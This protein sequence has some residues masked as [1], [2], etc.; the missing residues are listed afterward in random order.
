MT[1]RRIVLTVAALATAIAT[2]PARGQD[3][4]LAAISNVEVRASI[5]AVIVE[6]ERRGLPREPLVVKAL[7]GVEKGA[8]ADR[9]EAAVRA[10]AG[11]LLV[12]QDALSHVATPTELKAAADALGVGVSPTAIRK[13]RAAS[14]S[15]S[16]AVALGVLAQLVARGVPVTRAAEAVSDLVRR[17][18]G[19]PQLLALQRDVQADLAAGL[20]PTTALDLRARQVMIALPPPVPAQATTAIPGDGRVPTSKP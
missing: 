18:A 12:A 15:R 11:R 8:P 13:V 10:M 7:E 4:R 14:G 5:G 20:P 17:G 16:T 3:A 19:Q 9:I 2:R 6:A 1:G